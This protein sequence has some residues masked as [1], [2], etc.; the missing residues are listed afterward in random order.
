MVLQT[1]LERV[2]VSTRITANFSP[3][4]HPDALR[5]KT[6]LQYSQRCLGLACGCTEIKARQDTVQ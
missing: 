3:P 2:S 4:R 5:L 1:R 6:Q